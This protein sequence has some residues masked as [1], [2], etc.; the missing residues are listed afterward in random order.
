MG[1]GASSSMDWNSVKAEEGNEG[2]PDAD[3]TNEL[4]FQWR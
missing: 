2:E 1:C 4:E 3:D